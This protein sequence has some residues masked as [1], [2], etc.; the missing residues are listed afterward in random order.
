[1]NNDNKIDLRPSGIAG[2]FDCSYRWYRDT[3]DPI[4]HISV[5][6]HL[7][8][9]LHKA[10]EMFYR[11]SIDKA[12]WQNF[13]SSYEDIAI[14]EFRSKL[15]EDEPSDIKEVDLNSIES[16][17][18]AS[19]REYLKNARSLNNDVLPLAVEKT[20]EVSLKSQSIR[21][22]KGTLDIV[23]HNYIADIKTMKKFKNPKDYL[24]QQSLYAL[25]RSRQGECVKDLMIHRVNVT[26]N[27][28]DCVSILDAMS[29]KFVTID[30]LVDRMIEY[31]KVIIKTCDEYYKTGD[32]YAFRGNPSSLLCSDKYCAYYS[33]CKY[34]KEM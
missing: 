13:S 7:G 5:A 22:L 3:F 32:D 10:S 24:I 9:G 11:E 28:I 6:A 14:G 18:V 15:K 16:T 29:N 21:A 31:L 33:Q 1:M 26:K 17:I 2:F 20:Y 23:G 12:S 25:L 27:E 4:R 30:T 34:R 8:T 19:T